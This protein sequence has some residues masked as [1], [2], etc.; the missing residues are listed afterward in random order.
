MD[1]NRRKNDPINS[2]MADCT[3]DGILFSVNTFENP[4]DIVATL[5]Q[6]YTIKSKFY[7]YFIMIQRAHS[8]HL[9]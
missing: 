5:Q 2:T 1:E 8:L 3:A 9:N 4:E 7:Y 6:N